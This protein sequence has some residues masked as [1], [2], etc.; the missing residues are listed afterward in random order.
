MGAHLSTIQTT[1][2]D[3][4]YKCDVEGKGYLVRTSEGQL[5]SSPLYSPSC[6]CCCRR[7]PP[8]GPADAWRDDGDAAAVW[9]QQLPWGPLHGRQVRV[10]TPLS[11]TAGATQ[12]AD[13]QQHSTMCQP[14]PS[15][16]L[17]G[18]CSCLP[19]SPDEMRASPAATRNMDAVFTLDALRDF[20]LLA[21]NYARVHRTQEGAFM[22]TGYA[23]LQLWSAVQQ[24]PDKVVA[25]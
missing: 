17:E 24:D 23:S 14:S 10:S 25:W 4:F 12:L 22:V 1:L 6:S 5:A 8:C 15:N 21:Y 16:M 3:R 18:C 7:D 13:R 9:H 2:K 20:A 19:H 11:A